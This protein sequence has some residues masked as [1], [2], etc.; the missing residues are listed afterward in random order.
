MDFSPSRRNVS[1]VSSTAIVSSLTLPEEYTKTTLIG[2]VGCARA[3]RNVLIRFEYAAEALFPEIV[4]GRCVGW[5]VGERMVMA[6]GDAARKD[7]EEG[8]W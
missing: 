3:G 5:S 7:A 2:S 6:S 8:M 1:D 4:S